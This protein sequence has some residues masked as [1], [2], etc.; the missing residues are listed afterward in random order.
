[1]KTR[2]QPLKGITIPRCELEAMLLGAEL[3]TTV[4]N[5][6][7]RLSWLNIIKI[8][9]F[10]DSMTALAWLKKGYGTKEVIMRRT[11]YST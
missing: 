10:S 11:G 5:A 6:V 7:E 4:K 8:I 3:I 9:A 1:M 2:L